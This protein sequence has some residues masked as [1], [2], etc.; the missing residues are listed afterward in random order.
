MEKSGIRKIFNLDKL[1]VDSQVEGITNLSNTKRRNLTKEDI[2]NSRGEFVGYFSDEESLNLFRDRIGGR[3]LYYAVY[4][5]R[6]YVSTDILWV[7]TNYNWGPELNLD[8]VNSQYLEFQIPFNDETIYKRIYKVMPGEIVTFNKKEM[9]KER[10]WSISKYFN[11][12]KF[13]PKHLLDLIIDAVEF[14]KKIIGENFTSYLSGG[15]DSS[16]VTLLSKPLVCFTGYYDQKEYSELDYVRAVLQKGSLDNIRVEIKENSFY[17]LLKELPKIMPDPMAGLGVIPQALVSIAAGSNYKYA[18]TGEGGDEIFGG[19]PWNY[20]IMEQ[21]KNLRLLGERDKYL[22]GW[23]PMINKMLHHAFVGFTATA[24]GRGPDKEKQL[25]L[26]ESVWDYS[27][28][29]E[30]NLFLIN[31]NIGLPCILTVDECVGKY[32]GVMPVSPLVDHL[33]IEYVASINPEERWKIPKYLLREAMKGILPLKILYRYDK[34]GFP[35]PV[36]EW[37][38]PMLKSLLESLEKREIVNINAEEYKIMSRRAWSLVNIEII[39][40]CFEGGE[41]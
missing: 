41:K 7:V 34:M 21:V 36:S 30:N 23:G 9:F 22:I 33:I 27:E 2:I 31:I 1:E 15:I 25:K 3:N 6:V 38:W 32:S 39:C 19:Y 37:K 26:I 20:A 24:L 5:K 13:N 11:E 17:D 40:R 12:Q 18:F 4:G 14:R 29:V 28:S 10:Y 35:L 16:S 8:Y